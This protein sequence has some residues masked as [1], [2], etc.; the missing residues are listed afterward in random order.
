MFNRLRT[1]LGKKS[2]K[3]Q[4][5]RDEYGRSARQ[6]AFDDF[7]DGKR[8]AKVALMVGISFRTA[9]RY[10]ADWKRQP[11]NLQMRYRIAKAVLKND[12][13][14]R[15]KTVK[16]LAANLGMSKAEVAM[17]LQRPWGLKQLLLGKWPNYLREEIRNRAESRLE[18]A[19][20]IVRFV[21]H[22]GMTPEEIKTVLSKLIKG[23]L[24]ARDE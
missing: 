7:D 1:K 2:R 19:L 14:F 22:S 16:S 5:K 10:F 18:V 17:R 15:E 24:R 8:P 4:I 11:K 23:A 21:E 20:N 12:R 6:R 13:E 9:C 3:Y